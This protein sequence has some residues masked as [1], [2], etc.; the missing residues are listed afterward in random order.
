MGS[1]ATKTCHAAGADGPPRGPGASGAAA[2]ALWWRGPRYKT[3][4]FECQKPCAV[5]HRRPLFNR[6]SSGSATTT[7]VRSTPRAHTLHRPGRA[8]DSGVSVRRHRMRFCRAQIRPGRAAA[9][10]RRT[11][12]TAPTLAIR[13]YI[14]QRSLREPRPVVF[15]V[16]TVAIRC[17]IRLTASRHR[18]QPQPQPQLHVLSG[19]W[20]WSAQRR[21]VATTGGQ[22]GHENMS[23][24]RCRRSAAAPAPAEPRRMHCGGVNSGV[25]LGIKPRVLSAKKCVPW[26]MGAL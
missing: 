24:S 4:C 8:K 20:N 5:D 23:R 3:T 11:T 26:T 13:C 1:T 12:P 21:L 14:H 17:P 18:S 19:G 6:R 7:I 25:G 22:H 9:E 15:A 10:G 2:H 16:F